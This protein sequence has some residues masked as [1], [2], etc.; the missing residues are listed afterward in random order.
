MA[1]PYRGAIAV[2]HGKFAVPN[3]SGSSTRQQQFCSYGHS[4]VLDA[5]FDFLHRAFWSRR[6]R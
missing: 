5:V 4:D 1:S 3:P 2:A 6:D